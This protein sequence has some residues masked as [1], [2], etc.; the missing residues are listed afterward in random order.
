M[1]ERD[2]PAVAFRR[3]AREVEPRRRPAAQPP[4]RFDREPA[5]DAAG[6]EI[7]DVGARP[8]VQPDVAD[9]L[10]GDRGAGE[11]RGPLDR[12]RAPKVG[13]GHVDL[14][15]LEPIV[16]DAHAVAVGDDRGRLFAAVGRG[17]DLR[18]KRAAE[19][20]E[21]QRREIV[22]IFGAE[23]DLAGREPVRADRQRA[24]EVRRGEAQSEIVERPSAVGAFGDMGG[25][26]ERLA[27]DVAVQASPWRRGGR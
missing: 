16:A 11:L 17:G 3:E 14:E 7:G 4:A 22:E 13:D 24:R 15:T 12:P 8:R 20:R 26:G 23:G 1:G 25:A 19:L 21:N 2:P 6:V 18:L 5:H 9:R 10:A 27:V